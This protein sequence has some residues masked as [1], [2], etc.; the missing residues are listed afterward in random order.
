MKVAIVTHDG[1]TEIYSKEKGGSEIWRSSDSEDEFSFKS[2][3]EAELLDDLEEMEIVSRVTLDKLKK[4]RT[5]LLNLQESTTLSPLESSL[6]GFVLD[7]RHRPKYGNDNISEELKTL[8]ASNIGNFAVF[9]PYP[10]SKELVGEIKETVC[11]P[12]VDKLFYRV[13][14]PMFP[15]PKTY[16]VNVAG[17]DF[18][19]LTKEEYEV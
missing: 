17:K 19:I 3:I 1:K 13:V 14:V 2:R 16:S 6:I 12:Y 15:E 5:N 7:A 4:K 8:G 10:K 18:L 11:T 9:K